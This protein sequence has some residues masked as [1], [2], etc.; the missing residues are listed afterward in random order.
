GSGIASIFLSFSI[1]RMMLSDVFSGSSI[2]RILDFTPSNI[3]VLMKKGIIVVKEI[4]FPSC[5]ISS[6]TL[7]LHPT[8]AHFDAAYTDIFGF[9]IRPAEDATVHTAPLFLT[10]ISGRNSS[11]KCIGAHELFSMDVL[12]FHGYVHENIFR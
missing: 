12:Y 7:S 2:G 1:A 8:A 3:P 6:R 4:F 11:V 9:E 10:I 5:F